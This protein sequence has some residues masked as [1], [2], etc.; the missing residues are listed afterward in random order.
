MVKPSGEICLSGDYKVLINPHLEI[1]QYPLPHPELLPI[2][3]TY[4]IRDTFKL[5]C[6]LCAPKIP[7]GCMYN[8]L[9]MK[10]DTQY[11]VKGLVLVVEHTTNMITSKQMVSH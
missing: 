8:A 1:N 2:H 6:S 3:T 4:K 10:L 5:L 7:E 11:R 9:K